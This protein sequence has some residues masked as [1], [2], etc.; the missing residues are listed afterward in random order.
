M[1]PRGIIALVAFFIFGAAMSGLSA[2]ALL[3]PGSMLDGLWRLN[4]NAHRSLQTLAASGPV[5]MCVVSAACGVTAIGLLRQATWGR[6]L[7]IGL[8]SVNLF[9]DVANAVVRGDLRTLIGVPIAGVMI[10]Y[11]LS[12]SIRRA[13]PPRSEPLD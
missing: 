3:M 10:A 6:P 4:P 13:H 7:A 9:G 1:L 12:P 8:L 11:L 5:L 2:I